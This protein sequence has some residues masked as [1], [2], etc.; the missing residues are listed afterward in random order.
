MSASSTGWLAR[1]ASAGEQKQQR[2][3]QQQGPKP[4]VVAVE[5]TDQRPR[6]SSS[7]QSIAPRALQ[8]RNDW[9][10]VSKCGSSGAGLP[11]A[12]DTP[13]AQ[14]G[15]QDD[16]EGATPQALDEPP[17]PP[18]LPPPAAPHH[19]QGQPAPDEAAAG[20][21]LG[22]STSGAPAAGRAVSRLP[23]SGDEQLDRYLSYLLTGQ[24][25][26][27][28]LF[29]P[30]WGLTPGGCAALGAFLRRDTRIKVMTLAD[31]SIGD[32]GGWVLGGGGACG[33]V[34]QGRTRH[35]QGSSSVPRLLC[36]LVHAMVTGVEVL[37]EGLAANGTLLSLDLSGN[38]ITC[39]G[40]V[41]IAE[42]L[43]SDKCVLAELQ[44]ANNKIGGQAGTVWQMQV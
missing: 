27:R 10:R 39:V 40:A 23:A 24:H 29:Y 20:G 21:G 33:H 36:L 18:G 32:E 6:A 8:A 7:P 41:A 11:S 16:A 14:R 1:L 30:A 5:M 15:L 28:F 2:Q 17:E 22:R 44:L 9:A 13:Q 3:Q 37:A 38:D 35:A 4:C 25:P 26:H 42:A 12:L 19:A 34:C 31:N 43:H